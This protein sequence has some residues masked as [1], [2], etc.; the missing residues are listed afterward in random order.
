M[1]TRA[2][3]LPVRFPRGT[4]AVLLGLV[5]LAALG[6]RGLRS[7]FGIEQFLPRNDPEVI[8][9]R[10]L[11]AEHGR[12]DN[13]V[14]IFVTR[15]DLFTPKGLY[16]VVALA[17]ELAS[18]PL[19]DEVQS[20]ASVP[21]ASAGEAGLDVEA[22]FDPE[23][24]A[25]IDFKDLQKRLVRERVFARRL[26]S[27][28][29]RTTVLG[30]RVKDEFYGDRH[31]AAVVAH[32]DEVLE[33]FSGEG[34]EFLVTGNAPTRHRYVEFVRRDGRLFLPA[35]GLL[36]IGTLL[37]LFRRPAWAL[38]PALAL[39]VSLVFTFACMRLA[40][41]PVTLLTSAIPV[42]VLIVGLSDAIHLLTRFEEELAHGLS[43][44]AALERA[45]TATAHACFLSTVTTAVG[46]FVLPATGIPMLSDFG[47]VVGVGV[48]LAYLVTLT[49]LPAVIS[50]LPAPRLRPGGHESRRLAGMAEWLADHRRPVLIAVTVVVLGLGILGVPRLRVESRILDDLP[51]GHPLLATRAA[52]EARLGGNF[53]MTFVI[54]PPASEGEGAPALAPDLL[55]AVRRFQDALART[56]ETGVYSSSLSAADFL[57]MAWKASGEKGDLPERSEDVARMRQAVGEHNLAR[58]LERG[59]EALLVDV[60]VYD[61]GT[62]A[63]RRFLEHARR[64]FE[65]TVGSRA[66]LEVQ[67]FAY[68]AQ[69][70]QESVVWNS[71]TSFLLDFAIVT[72][73]VLVASRSWRL[74][75]F[76]TVP[77]LVPL[78][79]TLA[80]MGLA[81]I[82]LRI[83]SSIVFSIVYGIAIDDTVH[84]LA[85][86]QEERDLG[87]TERAAAVR[88]MATA[89]RAMIFM[90]VVLTV[91]FF[92]LTFS[93]F[94]PNRV[95]GLLMSVTV[96]TG[97]VA[98][99]VLLPALLVRPQAARR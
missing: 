58:L 29:G 74:S 43:R 38:L 5:A 1:L 39:G 23:R 30:V 48:L 89:G 31:R 93:Q 88:T 45:V 14:F 22:P 68:L 78:V 67:G 79:L 91:G 94:Q 49:L 69:R 20:L 37:V 64:S 9:Y 3:G 4:L 35:V 61:R 26:I 18:S 80:Y 98:D 10:Q 82:D 92:I 6:L 13:S 60:R 71:M 84:F 33:L 47:I 34:I 46:F 28:D 36:V 16:F 72:V 19:V 44:A 41:R 96:A 63:T 59:G 27:E 55:R 65:R 7:D 97:I 75:F 52:V 42:L 73:L 15:D 12:D 77:N 17:R 53:P 11:S 56:D 51:P 50:L 57:G 21:L 99:L 70:V 85:R 24:V 76:A 95:L 25:R 40:D 32:V 83:S 87:S 54:H 2:L 81:G 86:Y 90:A 8:R 62:A 66:R